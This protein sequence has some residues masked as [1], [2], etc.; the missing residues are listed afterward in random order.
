MRLLILG[1]TTEA[2]ELARALADDVRFVAEISLAGRTVRPVPQKL[3][4]R[5]GGFGG[6]EGL[7]RYL[8]E[9]RVDALIDATHPFAARMTA[10]AVAAAHETGT[11]LLVVLRPEWR[12]VAGDRW[13]MVG[14]MQAAAEALIGTEV[15]DPSRHPGEGRGPGAAGNLERAGLDS[16][17]RR[18]DKNKRVFLTVGQK[19]LFPFRALPH[20]FVLRSV[21]PPPPENLPARVEFIAARGPFLEADERRLLE[22]HRIDVVVTKNSGGT[23]TEAKL[24]AARALGVPVVMVQRPPIPPVPTVGSAADVLAWLE[25]HHAALPRGE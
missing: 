6:A 16:G 23:A 8:R 18:S 21:D 9:H 10:N 2:A 13:T 19:D 25:R 15:T 3:P 7:A 14:T 4:T 24:A 20:A 11:K 5:V 12:P 1:G 17:L 22:Q